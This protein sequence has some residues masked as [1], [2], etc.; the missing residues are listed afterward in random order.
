[1]ENDKH[2]AVIAQR[3]AKRQKL[4]WSRYK[5][6]QK[7]GISQTTLSRMEHEQGDISLNVLLKVA[8]ALH[9][10]VRLQDTN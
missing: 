1:M 3:I 8:D 4:G 2:T 7:T 9:L 10:E 5:L 6:F